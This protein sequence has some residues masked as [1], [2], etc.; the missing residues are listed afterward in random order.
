MAS[1]LAKAQAC[2]AK[3]EGLEALLEAEQ[4][5]IKNAATQYTQIISDISFISDE[6][7]RMLTSRSLLDGVS[8]EISYPES[9]QVIDNSINCLGWIEGHGPGLHIWLATEIG[10]YIWPKEGEIYVNSDGSWNKKIIEEGAKET[11]SLSLY[12]ANKKA[13]KKIRSW[14]DKADRTGDYSELR[15]PPGLRRITRVDNLHLKKPS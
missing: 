5:D 13:N 8:G 12:V 6:G 11:F 10:S 2:D 1:R 14:L 3:L 15:R 4:I 9:N 7:G